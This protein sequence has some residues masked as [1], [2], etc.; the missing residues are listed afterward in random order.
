MYKTITMILF[1][2]LVQSYCSLYKS[3][4]FEN[5]ATK[6]IMYSIYSEIEYHK[7][8]MYLN[9]HFNGTF[10]KHYKLEHNEKSNVNITSNYLFEIYTNKNVMTE[11]GNTDIILTIYDINITTIILKDH[12]TIILKDNTT[13]EEPSLIAIIVVSA[14]GAIY[15]SFIIYFFFLGFKIFCIPLI[16]RCIKISYQKCKSGVCEIERAIATINSHINMDPFERRFGS[17]LYN[18]MTLKVANNNVL[19]E[20]N[21]NKLNNNIMCDKFKDVIINTYE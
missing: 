8:D 12:I 2:L 19:I 5:N 6:T 7:F 13:I 14:T 1:F 16:L 9:I 3:T 21:K 15:M 11:S 20:R 10:Y 4:I 18:N 17:D